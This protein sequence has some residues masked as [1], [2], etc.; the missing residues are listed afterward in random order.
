MTRYGIGFF[1]LALSACNTLSYTEPTSGER[2]RVRFATTSSSITV[3]FS[4]DD[5]QCQAN[6]QEMMRLRDGFLIN[7]SPKRVGMP[8][9]EFNDNAAKEVYVSASRPFNA[10][11]KAQT[12]K[13]AGY[14]GTYLYQEWTSC[15]VPFSIALQPDHDYELKLDE[16]QCALVASEL[17]RAGDGY[18]RTP[19]AVQVNKNEGCRAA[20][21]KTRVY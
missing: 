14:N 5:A 7:A 11:I 1:V 20:F 16:G 12:Q 15:A 21:D 10:M 4:Y 6:E 19:V 9:W 13:G 8:L 18:T 2:A 17:I 3:L